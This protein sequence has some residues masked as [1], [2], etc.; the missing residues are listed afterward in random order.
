MV[1]PDSRKHRM[2]SEINSIYSIDYKEY[3]GKLMKKATF[4]DF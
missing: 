1:E 2:N 4:V 3:S